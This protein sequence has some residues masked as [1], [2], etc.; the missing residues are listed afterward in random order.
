M[1]FARAALINGRRSIDVMPPPAL[2]DRLSSRQ[3]SNF[4]WTS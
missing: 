4:A 1:S 3:N 2:M